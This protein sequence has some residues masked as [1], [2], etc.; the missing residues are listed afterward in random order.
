MLG[1]FSLEVGC[2]PC[3]AIRNDIGWQPMESPY[4]LG[5]YDGE[6]ADWRFA[7]LRTRAQRDEMSHLRQAIDNNP[8][9]RE[10][11]QFRQRDD[12]VHRYRG[13][14]SV[15]DVERQ[16]KTVSL[17][18]AGLIS[19]TRVAASHVI[20]NVIFH[21]IPEEVLPHALEGLVLAEMTCDL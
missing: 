21:L 7:I 13:P 20:A 14:G 2:K 16:Q 5:E 1:E 3:I 12:K 8:N 19:L 9:L 15:R 11:M 10:T 18:S 4:L 6:V 17:M